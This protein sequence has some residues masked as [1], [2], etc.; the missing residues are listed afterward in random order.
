MSILV[1]ELILI[2]I[3]V[4]VSLIVSGIL[5]LYSRRSPTN[6]MRMLGITFLFIAIFFA[7]HIPILFLSIAQDLAVLSQR[8]GFFIGQM[9]V[10][11]GCLAVIFPNF[12]PTYRSIFILII[13]SGINLSSAVFNSVTIYYTIVG[14][15]VRTQIQPIGAALWILS[16]VVFGALIFKRI[17]EVSQIVRDRPNPF[18]NP[19]RLITMLIVLIPGAGIMLLTPLFPELPSPGFLYAIPVSLTLLYFIYSFSKDKAFFFITPASLD[20]VIITHRRTGLTIYSENFIEGLPADQLLGGLFAA[21]DISLQE[22]I[23]T[24]TGLAEISFGDKVILLSRGQW[25]T[26]LLIVSEKN[27]VTSAA[28]NFITREFEKEFKELLSVMEEGKGEEEAFAN[29][30]AINEIR[31]YIPL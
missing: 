3:G 10:L 9:G 4:L 24:E 20:A 30:K 23:R 18:T 19:R 25:V 5:F 11:C 1:I 16:F 6:E 8:L 26:S 22:T 28:S 29:F 7:S 13:T 31:Y 2:L 21:L 17:T 27:F 14:D 15:Y 12:K